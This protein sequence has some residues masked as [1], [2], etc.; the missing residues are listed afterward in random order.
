MKEKKKKNIPKDYE[1]I[2]FTWIKS[3]IGKYKIL[4]KLNKLAYKKSRND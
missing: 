2:S 4:K 3:S 1:A